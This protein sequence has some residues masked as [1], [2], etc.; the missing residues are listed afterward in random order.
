LNIYTGTIYEI[1]LADGSITSSIGSGGRYDQIIGS[2]LDNGET[3]PTV[4]ISFGLDVIYTTLAE[5]LGSSPR[6]SKVEL[7]IIPMGTN[8]ECLKL[9]QQLRQSGIRVEMELSR[10]KLKKSLDYANKENIPF[11][12]IMGEN[13]LK[14][15]VVNL[16]NMIEGSEKRIA[17]DEIDTALLELTYETSKS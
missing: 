1:F 15:G 8:S 2:F 4:G 13:E 10:R 5:K 3:Y 11:V 7:F 17:L 14:D 12:I 16:K 9:A 6:S